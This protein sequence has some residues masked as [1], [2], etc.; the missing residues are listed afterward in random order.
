MR[1]V[2]CHACPIREGCEQ[3]EVFRAKARGL[4]A[5]SVKFRCP[6]LAK[7]LRPGARITVKVPTVTF[8]GWRHYTEEPIERIGSV[9]APATV[10][11]VKADHSFACVIDPGHIDGEMVAEGKDPNAMRFRKT[12]THTRIVAFLDEPPLP[13][14]D[15]GNVRRNGVCDNRDGRCWCLGQFDPPATPE[16]VTA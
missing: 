9:L 14:C 12:R 15:N 13:V 11:T 4:G 7:R 5:A 16:T 10:T 2:P 1:I 8:G 6:V 3:R